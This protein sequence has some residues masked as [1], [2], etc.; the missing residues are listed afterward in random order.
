MILP[1][2]I[3]DHG[4]RARFA[5]EAR[6]LARVDGACTARVLAADVDSDPAY[7]AL[8]YVSGLTLTE[9]V[10][11]FGPLSPALAEA[12]AVGLAEAL[13]AIH[14]V[15]VIHR[16]LKP[17]NVILSPTGPK[18]IDFGIAHLS[19]A[20]SL[21]ATGLVLGSPGWMAPEQFGH[22]ALT[23]ASDVFSWAATV[24][25]AATGRPPFGAGRLEAVYLRVMNADADLDGVGPRLLPVLSAALAKEPLERP[26]LTTLLS[27]LSPGVHVD[28]DATLT[29]D[30]A[31]LLRE[32][33][34]L[35]A[36]PP[37]D[38]PEFGPSFPAANDRTEAIAS[39]PPP[40]RATRRWPVVAAALA[41]VAAATIGV[42]AISQ[43]DDAPTARTESPTLL[44]S[45]SATASATAAVVTTAAS[46]SPSAAATPPFYLGNPACAGVSC[47]LLKAQPGI[48]TKRGKLRLEIF[49][50]GTGTE[51][52]SNKHLALYAENGAL[53]FMT[54]EP[55]QGIFIDDPQ[56]PSVFV[57]RAG[58][59][60]ATFGTGAHSAFL[61]V[62]DANTTPVSTFD[63]LS[64]DADGPRFFSN[65][66]GELRGRLQLGRHQRDRGRPERLPAELRRRNVH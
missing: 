62:L 34:T 43:P 49:K 63:S 53:V 61:I 33:W 51:D 8:E 22:Q 28:D 58:R 64:S 23:P 21:T 54:P 44:S 47:T 52:E 16:D 39:D 24:A 13:T 9:H 19:D 27:R 6:L 3:D 55:E 45:P 25:Y 42:V 12:L 57:D 15:G 40:R 48:Q 65:S 30:T 36:A 37:D 46:A 29:A 18:V 38:W 11:R 4:F 60:F 17:S 5:R 2:L 41:M 50:V 35:P 66:A 1:G 14:A 20:T 56:Y 31:Q 26:G 10:T 7:L 59:V 32:T